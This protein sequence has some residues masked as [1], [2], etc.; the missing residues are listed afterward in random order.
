M[1]ASLNIETTAIDIALKMWTHDHPLEHRKSLVSKCEGF[2]Q[3]P[4]K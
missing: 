1:A 2:A 3:G 4:T